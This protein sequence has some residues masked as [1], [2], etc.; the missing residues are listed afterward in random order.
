MEMLI[1]FLRRT[2]YERVTV[3]RKKRDQADVELK[4]LFELR[5]ALIEK[6]LK[7]IYSDDVFK[8]Q[9]KLLE[10]KIKDVRITK[11]DA[12]L[13]KYNLQMITDFIKD[14]FENLPKTYLKSTL[15]Q[16]RV[17]FCSIFPTGMLWSYPGYSNTTIS[18]YYQAILDL[19]R[20]SD[21]L[22]SVYGSQLEPGIIFAN[23]QEASLLLEQLNQLY[24][25][26][27]TINFI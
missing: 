12:L 10:G 2:Y 15:E 23:T 27:D 5:Q 16:K 20:S 17:L 3:L 1:A 14:K 8:E 9:N 11:D 22:S 25:H 19:N 24:R 26:L 21:T 7:G 6:N 4:E 18:P 13:D